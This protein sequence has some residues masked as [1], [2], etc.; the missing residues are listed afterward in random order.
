LGSNGHGLEFGDSIGSLGSNGYGLEFG[1]LSQDLSNY[2]YLTQP[3]IS[4]LDSYH[5]ITGLP[6]WVVIATS[7]VA[8][9]TALLPILILQRK[10]TKRISQFLPKL[11]HFWPPQGS[12][13]SVLDQLKLFRKERKDIGCP[14]FLWVPAYFSIQI[15]CFF[16]WITSIRRMSLDHHPGFDSGGALWFQNLTE[17][18]NGLYGPLFPFLIAGL[19]YT[20][21]QITFTASSVHKVD[22]FTELAKAYKTFLNLLTCALYFLSFQMPQVD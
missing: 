19:H 5:D 20:N 18:P 9:R 10:Q 3:V 6:W 2:D 15:S 22:K 13:R 21:T 14:S 17:I 1:D 7:T 16:L 8:F 11:P 4:L 12:G